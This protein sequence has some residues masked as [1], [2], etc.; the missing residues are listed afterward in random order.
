MNYQF[1]TKMTENTKEIFG[2]GKQKI[3]EEF[4]PDKKYITKLI[5]GLTFFFFI[6]LGIIYGITA[7]I[8]YENSGTIDFRSSL[9]LATYI[10][11]G[12]GIPIYIIS[13]IFIFPYYNSFSYALTTQEIIVNKGFLVKRTKIV[14]YRN[15]TNF[16]MRRGILDRLIGGENFGEI[17]VET[18]GQGP[19]Q[20]QPEQR[21]VGIM[22]VSGYTE[23]LRGILSKMK[24][25]AAL[26]ADMDI[27]SSLDEEE[28]LVRILATLKEISEKL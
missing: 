3:L 18:A 24:G 15:I 28:L 23:K 22:D 9:F 12:S 10:I 26:S 20:S 19:Q 25:Q 14:P 7:G 16:V 1:R 8:L 4:F 11:I 17:K 27:A 2:V 21:L 5:L 13:V 6:T